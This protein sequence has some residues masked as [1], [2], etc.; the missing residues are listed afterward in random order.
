MFPWARYGRFCRIILF[1][2]SLIQLAGQ[3]CTPLSQALVGDVRP[4]AKRLANRLATESIRPA[5]GH[6]ARFITFCTATCLKHTGHPTRRGA[7]IYLPTCAACW[8]LIAYILVQLDRLA[9][10]NSQRTFVAALRK[11]CA[12]HGIEVEIRS[13]GWL[14]VMRR[15]ARRHFAFGYDLGLNSAVAH[16]IANDKAATSEVLQICGIPCV[17]H[18]LF[19][20]PEMSEYVPPRRSWEAMIALL[21]ENPDGIVVKPNEGTSGESVFKVLTIPDL[22]V[23]AHKIFS[24]SIGIAIPPYLDIESEVRVILIDYRPLVT[25]SKD[26]PSIVADGK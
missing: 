10:L 22:E 3:C 7:A 17:P 20:S 12:N 11:Y 6:S 25:Y 14:I 26:R 18:T 19:L 9:M 15:G 23:D 4:L 13:E 2:R 1:E 16:R 24:S 21:K 5:P 8:Q